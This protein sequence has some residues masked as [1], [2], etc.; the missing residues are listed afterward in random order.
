M[1]RS[2]KALQE[3]IVQSG[4]R[5]AVDGVFG[6]QTNMGINN[7]RVP[8]WVKT[9]MK[10]IGVQETLGKGNTERVLDY[11]AISGGYSQDSV[12][13][14]G[15][16]VNWVMKENAFETVSIPARAKSWLKFGE[17]VTDPIIGAIAVKSRKGGGH[18]CFVIG[19]NGDHL[20][21]LGGN[22]SDEVNIR[23][24]RK[25]DFMQFRVPTGYGKKE[26]RHYALSAS[27]GSKE[28]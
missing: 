26:L 10:E 7:L 9:A 11:H 17:Q 13:W 6:P 23:S 1:K 27:S 12:A 20:Y 22:Q 2:V 4:Y 15:S 8:N 21:C 25:D 14:C 16:F 18:V 3:Y 24:Y 5:I 28:V 19:K